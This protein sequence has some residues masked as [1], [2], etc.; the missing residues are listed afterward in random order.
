METSDVCCTGDTFTADV[1]ISHFLVASEDYGVSSRRFSRTPNSSSTSTRSSTNS[2]GS[3]PL[4]SC[5]P[6]STFDTYHQPTSHLFWTKLHPL[7]SDVIR[8][9]PTRPS[10]ATTRGL[11]PDATPPPTHHRSTPIQFSPSHQMLSRLL[12]FP[13]TTDDSTSPS[14]TISWPTCS[15]SVFR[16]VHGKGLSQEPQFTSFSE[17]QGAK[18][19]EPQRVWF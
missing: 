13:T 17:W 18:P 3:F 4:H 5:P 14:T 9:Y 6:S 1:D 8:R 19:I 2:T 7:F 15:S 12:F 16:I 11:P 10:W